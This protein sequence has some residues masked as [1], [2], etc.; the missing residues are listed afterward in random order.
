[1]VE[2][3]FLELVRSFVYDRFALDPVSATVAGV[4]TH[5]HEYGDHTAAGYAARREFSESSLRRFEEAG[6]GLSPN[7][8]IDRDLILAEL[9]GERALSTFERWRRDPGLYPGV[10]T[11]GAYYG[12]TREN[13]QLEERLA[14][15]TERLE[16][17]PAV[18][19]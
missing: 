14:L 19:D 4:H 3:L 17:A 6:E 12:L 1:M 10:V 9:R 5:D 13:A 2:P 15:V 11:R 8:E 7:Q 16:Q 18:L